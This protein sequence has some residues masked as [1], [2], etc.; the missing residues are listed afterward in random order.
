MLSEFLKHC[1]LAYVLKLNKA[2]LHMIKSQVFK[3]VFIQE[4]QV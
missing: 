2:L 1:C 4:T 3:C